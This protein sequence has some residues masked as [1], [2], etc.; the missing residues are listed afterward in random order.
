MYNVCLFIGVA[1]TVF[2]CLFVY[3]SGMYNVCLFIEV[4]C[5]ML[6]CQHILFNHIH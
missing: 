1:C 3:W 4:A 5:T 2:V 6:V